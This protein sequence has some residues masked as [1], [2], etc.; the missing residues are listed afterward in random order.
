M[1][2]QMAIQQ[3]ESALK[4]AP[5]RSKPTLEKVG[6]VIM[7][8]A[9]CEMGFVLNSLSQRINTLENR[10]NLMLNPRVCP[11]CGSDYLLK[12]ISP[13][14]DMGKTYCKGCGQIV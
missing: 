5:P 10:L 7:E 2:R 12:V 13:R 1:D 14:K 9:E 11:R 6:L 8:Y 3:I 4:E